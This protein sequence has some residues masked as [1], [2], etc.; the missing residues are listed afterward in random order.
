MRPSKTIHTKSNRSKKNRKKTAYQANSHRLTVGII[1]KGEGFCRFVGMC[2][3]STIFSRRSRWPFST[4]LALNMAV[5]ADSRHKFDL[6]LSFCL[7]QSGEEELFLPTFA[8]LQNDSSSVEQ[9]IKIAYFLNYSLGWTFA[10][11]DL[12][13]YTLYLPSVCIHGP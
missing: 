5:N 7:N 3:C 11:R 4:C 10:L 2:F 13:N 1:F 8:K 6:V 12:M 9:T